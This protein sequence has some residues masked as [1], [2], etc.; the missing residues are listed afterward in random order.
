PG[1][2]CREPETGR[3]HGHTE[4]RRTSTGELQLLHVSHHDRQ[5]SHR[6]PVGRDSIDHPHGRR[7]GLAQARL[8]HS[9]G[10][11]PGNV[12]LFH[13]RRGGGRRG[14]PM[15]ALHPFN[16]G[17]MSDAR[18]QSSISNGSADRVRKVELLWDKVYVRELEWLAPGSARHSDV[19]HPYSTY[20]LLE[21]VDAN[22]D[23]EP[24]GTA[25]LVADSPVGLPIERF[26]PLGPLK[27]GRKFVEIQRLIVL[28]DFRSRRFVG[29]PF[30]LMARLM[31]DTMSYAIGVAHASHVVADVFVD[32]QVSPV[33]PL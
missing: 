25:R 29:A 8:P 18:V 15:T 7:M 1:R 2:P 22:G 5:N 12:R 14:R 6:G 21:L 32:P 20:I 19:Y 17:D 4:E 3:L 33:G 30:G 28:A 23:Q 26:F 24:V 13:E 10:L 9:R 31:R 16:S 27:D 11:L